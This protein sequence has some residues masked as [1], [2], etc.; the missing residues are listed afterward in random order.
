MVFLPPKRVVLNRLS[1]NKHVILPKR[2]VLLQNTQN[3]N[4][5]SNVKAVT[6][7][8]THKNTNH[9]ILNILNAEQSTQNQTPKEL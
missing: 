8:T 3:A 9:T 5:S 6:S 7:T 4:F 2:Y 1:G